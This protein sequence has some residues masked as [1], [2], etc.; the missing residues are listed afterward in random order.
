MDCCRI[1]QLEDGWTFNPPAR[2]P[3]PALCRP[4]AQA[5]LSGTA[6]EEG[7]LTTAANRHVGDQRGA[8]QRILKPVAFFQMLPA[9][10]MAVR[11]VEK[12]SIEQG[13]ENQLASYNDYREAM[14]F[15]R[16][17]RFE[18]INGD[19]QVV[20]GLRK[21]YGDVDKIEFFVGLFA[22]ESRKRSAVPSL[23]GRMVALDAF[24]QSLTNPLLSENVFNETTFSPEGMRI[25]ESTKSLRDIV[26]RNTPAQTNP[27]VSFD[28]VQT[29]SST[30]QPEA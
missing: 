3:V 13:R 11:L 15:P 16:V 17:T 19:P 21:V 28:Q 25:I 22:E 14:K 8:G 29:D 7:P 30:Q 2:T 5:L 20:E 9:A 6:V 4:F 10:S 18:Q 24:S 23:I 26:L 27:L 1:P 12:R